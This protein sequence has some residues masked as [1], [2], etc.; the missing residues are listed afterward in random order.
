MV[1]HTDAA[2]D[3]NWLL[4][5]KQTDVII[6]RQAG[7]PGH[8]HRGDTKLR[9]RR[10][11]LKGGVWNPGRR[12]QPIWGVTSQ[13]CRAG[14]N[15][16]AARPS[17]PSHQARFGLRLHNGARRVARQTGYAETHPTPQMRARGRGRATCGSWAEGGRIAV[18][19]LTLAAGLV[20]IVYERTIRTRE[21]G[22]RHSLPCRSSA[23]TTCPLGLPHKT[24]CP[25]V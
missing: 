13:P 2:F 1:G 11:S 4:P 9:D 6:P 7:A 5:R 18:L 24:T 23:G 22:R 10:R 15:E 17:S 14:K 19:A 3:L 12:S 25:M 21:C 20:W 16:R 8:T